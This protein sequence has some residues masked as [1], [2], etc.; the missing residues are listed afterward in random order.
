MLKKLCLFY[1]PYCVTGPHCSGK[2][3]RERGESGAKVVTL[4]KR[5]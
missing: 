1:G 2:P 3:R 5:I 4:T